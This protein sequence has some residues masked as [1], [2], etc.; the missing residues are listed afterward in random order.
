MVGKR[1]RVMGGGKR[2]RVEGGNGRFMGG[3]K[4]VWLRVGKREGCEKGGYGWKWEEG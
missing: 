2:G 4:G 1:V 3:E